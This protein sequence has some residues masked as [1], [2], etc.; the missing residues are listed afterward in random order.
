MTNNGNVTANNVIFVDS[1][2][3]GT[4]FVANSVT[5]NGVARP[6]AN[7]ASSI[8]LGSINASQTTVVR[9]Q[10]RVTSNPLVNPIPNRASA[11]FTFTPVPGQQPVSGQATSNTVVT[12]INIA[13]ITTRKTVDKAFAT[14][15]DVLTYT[16]TIQNTGNVLATNVVFQDPIPIGTTFITN[17]VTVDGVSQPGANPATGF[18]VANISPGGSRRVTFQVRVTSTPSGGTIANRGNVTANFVVIPNQPP[19]TINRQTNTVVT[20]VNTGGLN[21]I[22]E[23][24]TTQAAVG[25]TLTYTIAVQNTGNV[26]LTNVFSKTLFLPLFHLLQIL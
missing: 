2:P 7:P 17:S 10:V 18:T 15:N 19:I 25:D 5:V 23:V 16:V 3:A 13:D 22:K 4:T 20:Q 26:P 8:N 14:V 21:V 12:T 1:I 6:G 9:F 11:T 24:N